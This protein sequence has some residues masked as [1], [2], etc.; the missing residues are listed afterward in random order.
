[1]DK[2]TR[3]LCL[4]SKLIR[5]NIVNKEVF[6][7]E[8][9]IT[10]RS[11]DRDIEDIRLFLSETYSG[12]EL[13]Y[14]RKKEGYIMQGLKVSKEMTAVEAI[15]LITILKE[16]RALRQDEF[17][18]LAESILD[19]S[20]KWK[21]K[22]TYEIADEI[23]EKYYPVSHK[24][25]LMKLFWDLQLCIHDRNVIL[26]KYVKRS[27]EYV[28]RRVSPLEIIFLNHYFYL[29][30]MIKDKEYEYPAFYRVDR[31]ESFQITLEHYEAILQEKYKHLELDK[32]LMYMQ[33]GE[34]GE[35][36]VCCNN[37]AKENLLDTFEKCSVIEQREEESIIQIETFQEGFLQWV[38]GQ[39]ENVIVLQPLDLKNKISEILKRT[40]KRYQSEIYGGR[41]HENV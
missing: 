34:V 8:Y 14:D 3:M 10:K 39:S 23:K 30:A 33:G 18:G 16:S 5:G 13:K 22:E 37:S 12:Y 27:G 17:E 24:K 21:R 11:F 19:A 15:L 6:C 25:A 4:Y 9:E 38:L 2:V 26:L 1:M 36:T 40:L 20:E 29:V 41:N 32:K 7:R 31:V 28:K 35:I